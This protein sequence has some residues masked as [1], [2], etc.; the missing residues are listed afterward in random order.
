MRDFLEDAHRHMDDGYGRAQKHARQELPK[1]FY[2][3]AAVAEVADGYAIELDGRGIKTPGRASVVVPSRELAERLAAEWQAQGE[4]IDPISMPLMRLVNAAVEGGAASAPALRE[5]VVNYA[6]NDL[7]LFRADTPVE[8]V[9]E[10]ERL[11]GGVLDTISS[12]FSVTFKP[13]VGIIHEEQPPETLEKLAL[14]IAGLDH[15][16][17]TALMS[18]TNLT[19]SGLL[20][21][22]ILTG[23]ETPENAWFAAHVDEDHNLRL[24]GEDEEAMKR[25]AKRKVE[26]DAAVTVLGLS[27]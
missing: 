26:F 25:R 24:W 27:A 14:L 17:L 23:L 6:G 12:T 15:I 13:V 3:D 5:E 21:I 4:R 11:W 2:K 8:L 20:A 18:I 10:Q 22:A 19:G 9:E 16:S 7:M 1:R